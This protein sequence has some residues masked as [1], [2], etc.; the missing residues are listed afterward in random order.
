MMKED[1]V[2]KNFA[3][4]IPLLHVRGLIKPLGIIEPL[5]LDMDEER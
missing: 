2:Q 3:K 4:M 1:L 5:I